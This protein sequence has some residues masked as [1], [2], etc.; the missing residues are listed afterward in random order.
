MQGV[1]EEPPQAVAISDMPNRLSQSVGAVDNSVAAEPI[2]EIR[3]TARNLGE[4]GRQLQLAAAGRART[5]M[6][7]S[8]GE[9]ES[10]FNE[11]DSPRPHPKSQ[12]SKPSL[13]PRDS[14]HS[15]RPGAVEDSNQNG[16]GPHFQLNAASTLNGQVLN[17]KQPELI[18]NQPAHLDNNQGTSLSQ[19]HASPRT[20]P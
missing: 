4:D 12:T 11:K 16:L 7:P 14:I 17:L 10:Q 9:T 18:L 19:T 2:Q 8:S 5:V 15:Q 3:E 6:Q 13:L 1:I 20:G